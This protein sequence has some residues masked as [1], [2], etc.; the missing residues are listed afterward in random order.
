[1]TSGIVHALQFFL[2][3]P[4]PMDNHNSLTQEWQT[5]QGNHEQH[6][7]NA[8][9]IKLTCLALGVAGLATH[10]PFGWLAAA[11][12]L[13]WGQEGIIKTY[14]SRLADRLLVV[15]SLL[16]EAQPSRHAMQLHTDWSKNRPGSA[17][18]ITSY[19]ISAC[20]PTVAFPYLPILITGCIAKFI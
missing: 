7:R 4:P 18:L 6:E 5:L 8:L 12:I 13:L 2:A 20:R 16:R 14:Q 3:L 1:M 11:V 10:V 19:A 17:G 15:E 9:L